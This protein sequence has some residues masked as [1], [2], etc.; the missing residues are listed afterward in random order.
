MYGVIYSSK[1]ISAIATHLFTV[2]T[3]L[4]LNCAAFK[5]SFASI[6]GFICGAS[7]GLFAAHLRVNCDTFEGLFATHLKAYLRH[8]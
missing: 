5:S 4:K 6:R 7:E 2:A 1:R 8:I 3:H